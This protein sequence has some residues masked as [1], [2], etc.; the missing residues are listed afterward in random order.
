[1]TRCGGSAA[2]KEKPTAFLLPSVD[3]GLAMLPDP[4]LCQAYS[5]ERQLPIPQDLGIS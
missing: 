1:M 4:G 5:A 3:L 2:E